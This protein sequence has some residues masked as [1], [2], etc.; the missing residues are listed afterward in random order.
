VLLQGYPNLEYYVLDGASTD[1]SV[2]IIRKYEPWLAGWVSEPDGGQSAAINRG[3]RWA[4]GSFATWI[5]SDDMLQQDAL[6][7]QAE[8]YGFCDDVVYIGDCLYI[9]EDGRARNLHRGRVHNLED[10]VRIRT[11]WRATERRGHIV[12][13]EVLFPRQL[14]LDVGALDTGNHRTMDYELWGK[15]LLAGAAFQYTQIPFAMFRLHSAQKTG[16]GWAQTQ[17]LVKTAV[18]LVNQSRD[19]SQR[20]RESIIADL[21]A[22]ECDYWR[23]SGPLARLGLPPGVVLPIRKVHAGLRRHAVQLVRRRSE[24]VVF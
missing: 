22:Y 11:V 4:S 23:E 18:K 20:T 7:T 3:L 24:R 8:R 6:A 2:D 9:D 13:P 14:A 17:S 19:L 5:N 1:G 10:L 15:L 12:Q 16:E 21:Y